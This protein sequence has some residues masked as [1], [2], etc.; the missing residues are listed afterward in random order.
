MGAFLG[1][2]GSALVLG[3]V[4]GPHCMA[5]CG[6]ACAAVTGGAT[7]EP[8]E[9][10]EPRSHSTPIFLNAGVQTARLSAGPTERKWVFQLGRL[11]GYGTLGAL[12]ASLVDGLGWLASH[13]P[14]WHPLWVLFH[15]GLLA[16]GLALVILGRQPIWMSTLARRVWQGL[17]LKGR[18]HSGVLAIGLAWALMPCGLLYSALLLA[19][20]S[21]G[22]GQ[23]AATMAVFALG[24]A[25]A[26]LAGPA[27][28]QRLNRLSGVIGLSR[29]SR[30]AGTRLAGVLLCVD[31]LFA[32]WMDLS[33]S[34]SIIC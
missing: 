20:L 26:L 29:V 14:A 13:S 18:S 15:A 1:L 22:A 17:P 21:G 24:G 9:R 19:S 34:P 5:M 4:G 10:P 30:D 6:V 12:A 3:L 33:A 31:G 8:P 28:W 16:L 2:L 27:I 11:V 32:L 23:G 7:S 25:L